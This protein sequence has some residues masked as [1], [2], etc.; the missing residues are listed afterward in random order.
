MEDTS[1]VGQVADARSASP[2]EP[3]GLRWMRLVLGSPTQVSNG[4][5][6]AVV[7]TLARPRLLLP[8]HDRRVA[9]TVVR[10]S[11]VGTGPLDRGARR[12]ARVALRVGVLQPFLRS[13]LQAVADWSLVDYLSAALDTPVTGI[14]LRV[15][16]NRP[17]A[18]PVAQVIGPQGRLIGFAKL[19]VNP[20]TSRL[21]NGEAAILRQLERARFVDVRVPRV[22]HQGRWQD[23][24]IV[25]QSAL[26]RSRTRARPAVLRRGLTEIGAAFGTGRG[27]LGGSA[28]AADVRERIEL[29]PA[30]ERARLE[31]IHCATVDSWGALDL[32]FGL[33]HGDFTRWNVAQAGRALAVWDWERAQESGP[34]GL[35]AL[36]YHAG[37]AGHA[38]EEFPE[39]LRRASARCASWM[40]DAGVRGV[41]SA[42]MIRLYLTE[43]VLRGLSDGSEVDTSRS[44][45]LRSVL[46]RYLEDP[47]AWT[48][49]AWTADAQGGSS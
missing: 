12:V 40:T 13:R 21:V 7:P 39:V 28:Y 17:N 44:R 11:G 37:L 46:L 31:R 15:G 30:T 32:L 3:M 2:A 45:E 36:H 5:E 48:R 20:A 42:A 26:P 34:L 4:A 33:V 18:K 25:V 35:D 6:Y 38:F 24:D 23:C 8:L 9:S 27:P 22:L 47:E 41:T 49:R 1:S 29:A 43:L 19:G 16:S 14:G 10:W